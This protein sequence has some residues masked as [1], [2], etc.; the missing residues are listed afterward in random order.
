MGQREGALAVTWLGDWFGDHPELGLSGE[1]RTELIALAEA[2]DPDL[3][4]RVTDA[5]A[6]S[7]PD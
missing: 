1:E 4:A 3:L 5:V 7:E 6:P 2:V